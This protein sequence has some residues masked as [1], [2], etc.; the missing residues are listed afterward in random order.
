MFHWMGGEI[1]MNNVWDWKEIK[2]D[3]KQPWKIPGSILENI[4]YSWQRIV[5]GYCDKDLWNIDCWSMRVVPDM[6]QRFKDTKHGSPGILGEDYVDEDGILCNDTCH[7]AWDKIL[8]EMIFLFR[9][10]NEET[11]QKKNV[12]EKEHKRI[13]DEFEKKYGS[14][15]EKLENS[16]EKTVGKRIHFPEELPEYKGIEEK[17]Y[18]CEKELCE[19]REKCKDKAFELFAKWF[20]YLWD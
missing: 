13:Y 12:F 20:Y 2:R 5:K 3:L 8:E 15:G 4:R 19:Y 10:M 7:E 18:A 16:A 14:F 6:L 17:Y 1:L 11:C 9:E